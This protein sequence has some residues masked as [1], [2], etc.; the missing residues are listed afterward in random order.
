[1]SRPRISACATSLVP[2]RSRP[3]DCPLNAP[4]LRCGVMPIAGARRC[5]GTPRAGVALSATLHAGLLAAILM[6]MGSPSPMT[7]SSEVLV[8][9]LVTAASFEASRS[10]APALSAQAVRP[11]APPAPPVETAPP[12]APARAAGAPLPPAAPASP[13]APGPVIDRLPSIALGGDVPPHAH[14]ASDLADPSPHA[15]NTPDR[16]VQPVPAPRPRRPPAPQAAA[17]RAAPAPT[18]PASASDDAGSRAGEPPSLRREGGSDIAEAQSRA[19]L[20]DHA[21][22]VRRLI[23]RRRRYPASAL[24]AGRTGVAHLEL[25][26]DAAGALIALA[27]V[28]SS[29][30]PVLDE[31]AVSAARSAAPFPPIPEGLDQA[32]VVYRI[33]IRFQR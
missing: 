22:A 1:M 4:D 11:H 10:Q 18:P 19:A 30:W 6:Q 8:V 23:E 29:G 28:A 14:R 27:L 15:D 5:D 25:R 20:A 9:D 2:S 26:I 12:L 31:A 33:P 24:A 32:F 21:A 17:V 13:F 7:P 3:V 16:A